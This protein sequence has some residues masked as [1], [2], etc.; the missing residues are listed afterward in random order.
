[1][2]R[3]RQQKRGCLT[4]VTFRTVSAADRAFP[5]TL[6]A[7]RLARLELT[8][9]ERLPLF[10]HFLFPVPRHLGRSRRFFGQ[11]AHYIEENPIRKLRDV[12]S[13][14]VAEDHAVD[15]VH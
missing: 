13:R 8:R 9:Q 1:M 3:E 4:L 10:L 15:V 11:I 7:V 12:P 5:A 14:Q 2:K 6:P